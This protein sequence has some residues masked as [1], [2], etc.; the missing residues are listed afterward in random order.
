M[1]F[2]LLSDDAVQLGA[3][4]RDIAQPYRAANE[5]NIAFLPVKSTDH[6]PEATIPVFVATI[7]IESTIKAALSQRIRASHQKQAKDQ[8]T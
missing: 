6:G 5:G 2:G 3:R 8:Q 7:R 1:P 4:K